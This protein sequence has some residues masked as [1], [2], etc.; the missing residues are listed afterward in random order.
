MG[1]A[2]ISSKCAVTRPALSRSDERIHSYDTTV[3][4]FINSFATARAA[5]FAKTKALLQASCKTAPNK[6]LPCVERRPHPS[7]NAAGE[8]IFESEFDPQN[9]WHSGCIL[10]LHAVNRAYTAIHKCVA[11]SEP[12]ASDRTRLSHS[13]CKPQSN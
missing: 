7:E 9:P 1:Q 4:P 3:L 6:M 13:G 5:R 2:L 12:F 8:L 11:R 10:S